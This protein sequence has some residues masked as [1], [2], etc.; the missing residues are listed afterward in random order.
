M[1]AAVGRIGASYHPVMRTFPARSADTDV[2]AN[3]VHLELLRQA[4]PARRAALAFS[5]SATVIDLAREALRREMPDASEDERSV[6]FVE[7]HHGAELA[8][9]LR[10]HLARRR[11]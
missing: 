5:L 2:E 11:P 8:A 10:E 1:N 3:A 6:R 4:T 9:G 7:L